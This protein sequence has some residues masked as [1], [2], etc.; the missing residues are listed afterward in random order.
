MN[1]E[2]RELLN[3]RSKP[4]THGNLHPKRLFF[5]ANLSMFMIGLG[6]A[7]RANIAKDLQRDLFDPVDL[8]HSAQMV[9][10]SLGITFTG[11][12]LTLLF[13]SAL[14]DLVGVRRVLAFSA[15]GFIG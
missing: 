11:F 9:G 8:A 13:V 6:F 7:V 4:A 2:K 12:A 1:T 10:Q 5:T 3:E 15:L 14:V